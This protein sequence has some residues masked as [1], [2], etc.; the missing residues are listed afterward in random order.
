M[1]FNFFFSNQVWE[2]E[3]NRNSPWSFLR[4][5]LVVNCKEKFII[6]KQKL[7]KFSKHYDRYL[8]FYCYFHPLDY[9]CI[10]FCA[11]K[12][13]SVVPTKCKFFRAFT[14]TF[15]SSDRLTKSCLSGGAYCFVQINVICTNKIF[16]LEAGIAKCKRA[17]TCLSMT[18]LS[19]IFKRVF[20]KRAN[21]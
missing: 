16:I 14:V 8:S 7:V 3:L 15:P 17:V 11:D 1:K 19:F 2:L 20:R 18:L 12:S 5:D 10:L 4:T 9:V 13:V 6:A 21:H